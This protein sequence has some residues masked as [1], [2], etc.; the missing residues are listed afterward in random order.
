MRYICLTLFALILSACSM[1]EMVEKAVPENVRANHTA[2][3]DEILSKNKTKMVEALN[4]DLENVNVQE[5]LTDI[6]ENIPSG[7][8]IRRDYVGMESSSGFGENSAT[9]IK[10]TTEIQT[11]DGFLTVTGLYKS[12]HG[13]PCCTLIDMNAWAS[14]SSPARKTWKLMGKIGRVFGISILGL[15]SGLIGYL[16]LRRRRRPTEGQ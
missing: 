8:E 11:E 3:I 9:T 1:Q 15:I 6:F 7:E 12:A 5:R 16:I 10:L 14:D 2:H 13:E 4:L